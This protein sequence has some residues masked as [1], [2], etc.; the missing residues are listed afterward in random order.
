MAEFLLSKLASWI[1]DN[2]NVGLEKFNMVKFR[3]IIS[4]E[5]NGISINKL[6]NLNKNLGKFKLYN[7]IV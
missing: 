5:R 6:I 3:I 4:S 1:F 2:K 7:I